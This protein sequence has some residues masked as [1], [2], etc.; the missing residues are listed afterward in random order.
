MTETKDVPLGVRLKF[1]VIGGLAGAAL[2][3]GLRPTS[4][5]SKHVSPVPQ[6]NP[7][8]MSTPST[9][10]PSAAPATSSTSVSKI[11]S[12]SATVANVNGVPITLREVENAL[13]RKEGVEQLM[14][15]LEEHFKHTNW[16][17]VQDRDIM[18]QTQNWR[19]TRLG[20]AAQLLKQ[21]AGDAR[22]DLIGIALVGQA[23]K[24]EAIVIDD[25]LI[26]EE[27]KRMEKRHYES[28]ESAKK[29]YVDFKS[30]IEQSQKMPFVQY[31]R[32]EGFR[33]GAGIRVLVE[34]QATKEI[35]E[36]QIQD[37]FTKNLERYRVQPAADV[38]SIFVP[39]ERTK[40]KDG[41]EIVTQ[42]EKDRLMGVM[43][44]L[45]GAISRRQ[46]TFAQTYRTFGRVHEQHANSEGRLGWINRDGT[47]GIKGARQ[48][49]A[50]AMDE[51]FAVQPPFPVL[52]SPLPT[53]DGI[54]LMQVHARRAGQ[55]P[56]LADLR[57]QVI[58]DIVDKELPKR[59]QQTL[60]DLRRAAEIDYRSLPSL[61]EQ[62]MNEAGLGNVPLDELPAQP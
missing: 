25:A 57:A 28:L 50:R 42:Q 7:Q 14:T 61:I 19:L 56:I 1:L 62:R 30:F 29:T 49:G 5:S 16:D 33:M 18:V 37:W 47:R 54:E 23:L 59:T 46:V 12:S 2:V 45:H 35:S 26:E 4:D 32:Q 44:Q 51:A 20:V 34:R 60:N 9:S 10:E 52:L 6:A 24:R 36:E 17:D 15:M 55:E 38:S 22:E 8:H 13:L 53:E 41:V 11:D 40:S 48:I 27:I 43:T 3:F 21:K 58:G 31:V 39:Y